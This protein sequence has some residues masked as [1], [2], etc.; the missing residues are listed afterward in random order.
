MTMQDDDRTPPGTKLPRDVQ[1]HLGRRLRNELQIE[2]G[3][4]SFLGEPTVP[5]QFESLVRKLE[6][7]QQQ[8]EREG[9]EAVKRAILGEPPP[10]PQAAPPRPSTAPS[11]R[12]R[13]PKRSG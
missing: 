1:E 3:K 5:P 7:G 4:P 10:D 6:A 11:P 9:Y 8:G 12:P 13:I 2:A